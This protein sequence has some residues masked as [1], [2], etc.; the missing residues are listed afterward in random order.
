VIKANDE[1]AKAYDEAA[2][3]EKAAKLYANSG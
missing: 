1:V 3:Y 2:A